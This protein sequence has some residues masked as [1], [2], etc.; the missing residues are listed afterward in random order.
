M[1]IFFFRKLSV[2]NKLRIPLNAE[3]R[4]NLIMGR[5]D[6]TQIKFTIKTAGVKYLHV[7]ERDLQ[8]VDEQ[9]NATKQILASSETSSILSSMLPLSNHRTFAS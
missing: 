7:L 8:V 9:R 2:I 6:D 5:I 3:D 1:T 4:V